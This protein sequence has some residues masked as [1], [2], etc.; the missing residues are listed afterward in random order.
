MIRSTAAYLLAL[1]IALTS[2]TLADARGASHDLGTD[3][4][5]CSGIGMTFVTVG[6]DGQPVETTEACPD[7]SSIFAA[8]FALPEAPAPAPR[9]I[10]TLDPIARLSLHDRDALSPAAR[11]PPVPA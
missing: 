9:L 4:A 10:A 2:L 7:G 1:L 8:S 11:G 3:I 5:I 6:P